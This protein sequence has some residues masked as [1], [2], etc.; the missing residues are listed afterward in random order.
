MVRTAS[1]E[2]TPSLLSKSPIGVLGVNSIK[3]SKDTTRCNYRRT[4]YQV[5]SLSTHNYLPY[6]SYIILTLG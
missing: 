5:V 3:P 1:N 6:T 2:K 4:L